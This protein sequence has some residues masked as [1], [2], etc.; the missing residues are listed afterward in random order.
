M[1]APRMPT[2]CGLKRGTSLGRD[3]PALM[4][5]RLK[6]KVLTMFFATGPAIRLAR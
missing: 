1:P 5:F 4:A 3:W 2:F 6:K